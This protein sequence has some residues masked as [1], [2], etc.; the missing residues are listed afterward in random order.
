MFS[1]CREY[2]NI[3]ASKFQYFATAGHSGLVP[4]ISCSPTSVS[5]PISWSCL[6]YRM[7]WAELHINHYLGSAGQ[8]MWYW[9][10]DMIPINILHSHVTMVPPP[11]PQGYTFHFPHPLLTCDQYVFTGGRADIER[12]LLLWYVGIA[13]QILTWIVLLRRTRAL[14]GGF[15]FDTDT[16]RARIT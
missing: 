13:I 8:R 6:V 2:Q 1:K 7:L 5:F 14:C 16:A 3:T 4:C 9:D 12:C 10:K 11:P 15:D